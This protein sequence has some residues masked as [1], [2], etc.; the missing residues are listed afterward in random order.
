MWETQVF[1]LSC[2]WSECATLDTVC[3]NVI[4]CGSFVEELL[5]Q[6]DF[7]T[8]V[9]WF[10]LTCC[11]K[12]DGTLKQTFMKKHRIGSHSLL[13]GLNEEDFLYW[14]HSALRYKVITPNFRYQWYFSEISI[15][16]PLFPLWTIFL[17][18]LYW[19]SISSCFVR[20]HTE[21]VK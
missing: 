18:S 8:S 2:D 21:K 17:Y 12:C 13:S 11:L 4:K 9:H 5:G 16:N 10:R 3:V 20:D 15:M 7:V 6:K 19:I 14:P 1:V